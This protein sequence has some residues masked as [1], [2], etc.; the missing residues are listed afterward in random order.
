[1][2]NDSGMLTS[3]Q[4]P[5]PATPQKQ[6]APPKDPV[7]AN[8]H[9]NIFT[10]VDKKVPAAPQQKVIPP[11]PSA[12]TNSTDGPKP[13]KQFAQAGE[14]V[15]NDVDTRMEPTS[16]KFVQPP[17]RGKQHGNAKPLDVDMV[18]AKSE[19]AK[20]EAVSLNSNDRNITSTANFGGRKNNKLAG[21]N[22]V[23]A[24]EPV[25]LSSPG[26]KAK[27]APPPFQRPALAE[28]C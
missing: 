3:E 9:E 1:M 27:P 16:S 22:S 18:S 21:Y 2:S 15:Q 28:N 19:V 23:L 7:P 4:A 14:A 13:A 12:G 24:G 11:I 17:K 6:S 25:D 10:S 26:Q 8:Q 20:P 5:K